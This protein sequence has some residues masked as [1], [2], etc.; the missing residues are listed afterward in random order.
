M[1]FQGLSIEQMLP[2]HHTVVSQD[3]TVLQ[4]TDSK[5]STKHWSVLACLPPQT[6]TMYSAP[7]GI[8][9]ETEKPYPDNVFAKSIQLSQPQRRNDLTDWSSAIATDDP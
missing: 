7:N 5:D 4:Y 9:A 1:K 8:S 3:C 2:N 6:P